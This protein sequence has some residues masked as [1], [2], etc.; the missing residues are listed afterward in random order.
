VKSKEQI[1]AAFDL[2]GIMHHYASGENKDKIGL[3]YD[4]LA[5]ILC[6]G[7]SAEPFES[8]LNIGRKFMKQNNARITRVMPDGRLEPGADYRRKADSQENAD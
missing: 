3:Q 2:T 1:K 4:V 6:E 7:E 8:F 5:W